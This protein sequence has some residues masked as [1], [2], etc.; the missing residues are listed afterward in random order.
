MKIL[1]R[2]DLKNQLI[3]GEIAPVYMLF[4][5]ETYLRDSAAKFIADKALTDSSLREFNETVFSLADSKIDFAL[6]AAEQMPMIS[7]R[8]VVR[9]TEVVV[10]AS[11]KKETLKEE[12]ETVLL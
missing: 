1:S 4:G 7:S 11:G 12:D 8:R 9:I 6:S 5:E 3:K 2:E 10:S